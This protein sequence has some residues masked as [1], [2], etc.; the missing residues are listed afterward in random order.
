M[1]NYY[2]PGP[3]WAGF[4][5]GI[6]GLVFCVFM[7]L[8]FSEPLCI[9]SG[10]TLLDTMRVG[11]ISLWWFGAVAFF[12]L[13]ILCVMPYDALA[14]FAVRFVLTVDAFLLLVMLFAVP[15][16]PCLIAALIFA[17]VF[18]SVRLTVFSRRRVCGR[19]PLLLVW[20]VL[21]FANVFPLFMQFTGVWNISGPQ[22]AP[23]RVFFSPSCPVCREAL[24]EGAKLP[25]GVAAYIPVAEGL[26][27]V[28][29]LVRMR[30]LLADDPYLPVLDAMNAAQAES[31]TGL[32]SSVSW[33]E[34]ARTGYQALRNRAYAMSAGAT[35]LPFFI[36]DGKPQGLG[37]FSGGA[38][39]PQSPVTPMPPI[40]VQPAPGALT[41]PDF[42]P[43]SFLG[44]GQGASAE[45]C[46]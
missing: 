45:P 5:A 44:C 31:A 30:A 20:V 22:D 17:V 1:M 35:K 43:E 38:A 26:D 19:S 29:V 21:F 14:L 36:M 9:T 37:L 40:A 11:G 24:A 3:I 28:P 18:F 27:D 4:I 8:G 32:W 23:V 39:V 7:L 12:I 25:Y 42:G 10:C 13:T 41:L 34:A 16:F 33:L 2:R 15:C 46:D 6:I